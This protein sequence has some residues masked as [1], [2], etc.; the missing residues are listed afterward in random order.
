VA[1]AKYVVFAM[2]VSPNSGENGAD[3]ESIATQIPEAIDLDLES[4][5]RT[6]E[7][8]QGANA[9]DLLHRAA[10]D[11]WRASKVNES[12]HPESVTVVNQAIADSLNYM[13][14]VAGLDPDEAQLIFTEAKHEQQ[15]GSGK[16]S[17]GHNIGDEPPPATSPNDYAK[18]PQP[19][20]IDLSNVPLSICEWLKRDLSAPDRIMGEW[21][22]TTSRIALNAATGLGK[23]N[24]ALALAAYTSAGHNFLHWRAHRPAHVLFVD[25]E[26]SRRL[27]KRR[28]QDV[29]R[30]CGLEPEGLFLL[31]HEDIT[32]FPPL[33]TPAGKVLI[34]QVIEKIGGVD[35]IIFDNVMALVAGD[36]KE[37]EGWQRALPLVDAL[38]KRGIRQLWLHHTG[39][40]ASRGYGTKT[41]EWRMDTVIHLTEEKRPDTDVSFRLEFQ[42]ARERT[43]ETRRD[44]EDVTIAL[45]DD[46]WTCSAATV[47]RG[48]PSPM[49]LKFL[50]ALRE[51]FAGGEVIPYQTWK[52]VKA[53]AWRDECLRLGLLDRDKPHSAR[54]LFAKYRR[55]L[56]AHNLV[57]CNNNLVW[58][59]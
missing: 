6:I 57:A 46:K 10:G 53:D 58:L 26:M 49:E 48:N 21:F 33:N 19:R 2:T 55:E 5:R 7:N 23:T 41:R 47:K 35:A 42:K 15:T 17:S 34:E 3:L 4:W 30:R 51:V 1:A 32:G 12:V 9:R 25:G 45:V 13:A 27:L 16:H 39:H 40:D 38:T 24:F 54:T 52:A 44:F 43:P 22:T 11:L 50:E 56:V 37:E 29:S 31:S 59:R 20:L 18:A 28:A 14:E 36:M 8:A